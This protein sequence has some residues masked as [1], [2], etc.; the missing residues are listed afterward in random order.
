[1]I[2]A[3]CT[4]FIH[5]H[6]F[7]QQNKVKVYIRY[8]TSCSPVKTPCAEFH[9]RYAFVCVCSLR[10]W[11]EWV[12]ARNFLRRSPQ[13]NFRERQSREQNSFPF[14]SR[15]PRLF[16]LAFWTE[17]RAGT[18]SRRLRR[19]VFVVVCRRS[20]ICPDCPGKVPFCPG[21]ISLFYIKV[22]CYSC[23]AFGAYIYI[24]AH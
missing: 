3:F 24:E 16:A 19:S 21:D 7:A 10:R 23:L 6:R 14:F 17:V 13:G 12:R 9:A 11:R 22:K 18:H 8:F 15:P 20:K 4:Q 1:M 2:H 5:R